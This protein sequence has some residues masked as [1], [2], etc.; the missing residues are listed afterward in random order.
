[1]RCGSN[2]QTHDRALGGRLVCARCGSTDLTK[3]SFSPFRLPGF[4]APRRG[5]HD[6][7]K[8]L[9]AFAVTVIAV[10]SWSGIEG[11][12]STAPTTGN[13]NETRDSGPSLD[14]P[15][16][17]ELDT[18]YKN[19]QDQFNN[20]DERTRQKC[21]AIVE[22]ADWL[23]D[24]SGIDIFM[25][26]HNGK[27]A[28]YNIGYKPSENGYPE[29]CEFIP[30]TLAVVGG[31]VNLFVRHPSCGTNNRFCQPEAV[32]LNHTY[33]RVDGGVTYT[34]VYKI[35]ADKCIYLYQQSSLEPAVTKIS[36]GC[37]AQK[38]QRNA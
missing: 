11:K 36:I 37:Q 4:N 21:L 35:E 8:I 29:S 13:N 34:G 28:L 30:D 6:K 16:G 3:T 2:S 23:I 15:P 31:Y 18:L 9:L 25:V 12:L 17:N 10:A 5:I 27:S 7:V 14:S 32:Y 33:K 22:S 26:N 38:P 20:A 19:Q 24:T 1:M